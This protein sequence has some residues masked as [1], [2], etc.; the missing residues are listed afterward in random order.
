MFGPH[1][2][3]TLEREAGGAALD[4]EALVPVGI[5]LVA[6][7]PYAPTAQG[8]ASHV[9]NLYASH[10]IVNFG[11]GGRPL[12]SVSVSTEAWDLELTQEGK[13]RFPPHHGNEFRIIGIHPDGRWGSPVTAED[14]VLAAARVI[15]DMKMM[16]IIETPVLVG[17]AADWM[18]HYANWR[19][20]LGQAVSAITADGRVLKTDIVYLNSRDRGLMVPALE[21]ALSRRTD[22]RR[23]D[24]PNRLPD[25]RADLVGIALT[26]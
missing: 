8:A 12:V 9:R 2:A 24:A 22:D 14:A 21:L 13:L 20:R 5:P 15:P 16:K 7:T 17:P 1:F 26:K 4:F 19:I 11:Y 10:Y 25:L 3:Q 18:P 23:T 6:N